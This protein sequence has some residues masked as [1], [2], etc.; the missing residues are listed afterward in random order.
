MAR[1]VRFGRKPKLTAHQIAEAPRRRSTAKSEFSAHLYADLWTG[2]A[3][4]LQPIGNYGYIYVLGR[5]P[6][7]PV[8]PSRPGADA[9]SIPKPTDTLSEFG[10]RGLNSP[11]GVACLWVRY[12]PTMTSLPPRSEGRQDGQRSL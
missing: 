1:G 5:T 11:A 9:L 6:S 4:L 7:P 8:P 12:R 2:N 10:Y 3:T